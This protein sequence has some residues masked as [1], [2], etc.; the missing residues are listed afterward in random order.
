MAR[1]LIGNLLPVTETGKA[2]RGNIADHLLVCTVQIT[3]LDFAKA[4]TDI[5]AA[6]GASATGSGIVST[7]TGTIF[8]AAIG[9][10]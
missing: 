2:E 7:N 3:H 9:C 5:L 4:A 10:A 8:Q 6:T 1:G